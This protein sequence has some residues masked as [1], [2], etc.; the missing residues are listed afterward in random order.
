M[1]NTAKRL[2]CALAALALALSP[3]AAAAA[4]AAASAAA[5]PVPVPA[6]AA[7]AESGTVP[8]SLVYDGADLLSS[9]EESALNARAQQLTA[10]YGC[11]V[12]LVTV[13][14]LDGY[15]ASGYT[16]QFFADN[17]VGW[18][19]DRSCV[20]LLLSIEYRDYDLMAHGFGNTAF[21]DYAKQIMED[22]FL[23]YFGDDDYYGGFS[24]YLDSCGEYLGMAAAGAPFDVDNDPEA[25]ASARRTKLYTGIAVVV[26]VPLLAAF[27]TCE[28]LRA[29]MKTARLQT[30]ARQYEQGGLELSVHDDRFLRTAVT[31]T[32]VQ[33]QSSGGGGGGGTSVNS[34]GFSHSS[35]K[36]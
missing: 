5:A 29:Q 1:N 13:P 2:L 16:E 35:G 25:E 10:Q 20:M 9:D 36:F 21:T 11:E 19:S 14:S 28:V 15:T 26:L 8:A 27:I 12:W 30:Q 6:A 3:A 32:R 17:S 24:S 34:G 18:G 4:S 22:K 33:Q 31:R 7:P 23:S